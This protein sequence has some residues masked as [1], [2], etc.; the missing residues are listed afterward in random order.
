MDLGSRGKVA[1]VTGGSKGIG[2]PVKLIMEVVISGNLYPLTQLIAV[3]TVNVERIGNPELKAAI[4]CV[5]EYNR[6][7]V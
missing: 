7:A 3:C 2:E 6:W 4:K 1:V 5:H